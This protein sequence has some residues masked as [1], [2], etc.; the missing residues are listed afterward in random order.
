[1]WL[2]HGLM[3]YTRVVTMIVHITVKVISIDDSASPPEKNHC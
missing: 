2:K 1:M 3:E